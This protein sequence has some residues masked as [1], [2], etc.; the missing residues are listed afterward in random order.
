MMTE[1]EIA[2]NDQQYKKLKSQALLE[3]EGFHDPNVFSEDGGF[4]SKD[5]IIRPA[6]NLKLAGAEEIFN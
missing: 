4:F 6:L 1:E 2:M 5:E 3:N